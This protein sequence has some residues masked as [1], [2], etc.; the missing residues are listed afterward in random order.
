MCENLGLTVQSGQL[1]QGTFEVMAPM[2]VGV[3]SG[4]GVGAGPASSFVTSL[5]RRAHEPLV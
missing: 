4:M 2:P 3:P 5:F 1:V